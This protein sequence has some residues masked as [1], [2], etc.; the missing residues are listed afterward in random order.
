MVTLTSQ[1]CDGLSTGSHQNGCVY[2]ELPNGIHLEN[3]N[4]KDPPQALD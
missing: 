3:R 2:M 1:L 4:S